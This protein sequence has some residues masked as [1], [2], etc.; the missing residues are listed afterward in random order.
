MLETQFLVVYRC[1][2][3]TQEYI[4][5]Y[6]YLTQCYV[7]KVGRDRIGIFSEKQCET[8]FHR[9]CGLTG[10]VQVRARDRSQPYRVV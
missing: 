7:Y 5:S 3:A 9:D 2:R 6:S 8:R 4:Q 1:G 10:R